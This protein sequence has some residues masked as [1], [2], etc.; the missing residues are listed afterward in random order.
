MALA[1]GERIQ[2]RRTRASPLLDATALERSG[3]RPKDRVALMSSNA[4]FRHRLVAIWRLGAQA[5]LLSPPG[6]GPR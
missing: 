1:F 4:E 6:S 5:V 3:V 2:P